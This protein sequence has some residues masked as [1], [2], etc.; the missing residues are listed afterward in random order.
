[1]DTELPQISH[2]KQWFHATNPHPHPGV[3][4]SNTVIGTQLQIHVPQRQAIEIVERSVSV[5]NQLTT[6]SWMILKVI[7]T[8]AMT[9]YCESS[10][11][12]A[13]CMWK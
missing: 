13:M 4:W 7:S 12:A 11:P 5:I 8:K 2:L 1:M 6:E 10:T 3:W 9:H